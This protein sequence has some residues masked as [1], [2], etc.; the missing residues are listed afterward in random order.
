MILLAS[1]H[2]GQVKNSRHSISDFWKV[3]CFNL[4]VRI[5]FPLFFSISNLDSFCPNVKHLNGAFEAGVR[6]GG[7]DVGGGGG[8]GVGRAVSFKQI[9]IDNICRLLISFPDLKSL[10]EFVYCVALDSHRLWLDANSVTRLGD[11]WI[12][13][14]TNVAYKSSPNI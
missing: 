4:V 12:F 7:V 13:Y 11:F 1:R 6:H 3:D 9:E 5:F 14:L 2:L 8:C 10:S